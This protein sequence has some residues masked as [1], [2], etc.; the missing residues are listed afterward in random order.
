MIDA[1]VV[2]DESVGNA[3]QLQQAIPVG[4]VPGEA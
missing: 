1:V 2:A 3:A 4:V